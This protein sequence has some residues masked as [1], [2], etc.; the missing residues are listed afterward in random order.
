MLHRAETCVLGH[1]ALA[2]S[3]CHVLCPSPQH[4]IQHYSSIGQPVNNAPPRACRSK[5]YLIEHLLLRAAGRATS[6]RPPSAA[7]NRGPAAPPT[8]LTGA[9]SPTRARPSHAGGVS[10]GMGVPA[11]GAGGEAGGGSPRGLVG[12]GGL[13][14]L[15][16][17]RPRSGLR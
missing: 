3:H 1:P 9:L 5:S 15:S 16:P 12:Y 17:G 7:S 10:W 4:N 13:G 8:S 6:S 11:T 2:S 14:D